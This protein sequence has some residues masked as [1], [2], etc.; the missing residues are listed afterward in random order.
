[1]PISL[2]TEDYVPDQDY[3]CGQ[4]LQFGIRSGCAYA[5]CG[6]GQT[7]ADLSRIGDAVS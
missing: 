5:L 3:R 1:M 2:S 6:I 7:L 4:I